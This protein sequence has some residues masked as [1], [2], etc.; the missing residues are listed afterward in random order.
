MKFAHGYGAK[1]KLLMRNMDNLGYIKSYGGVQNYPEKLHRLKNKLEFSQSLATISLL[2]HR[3]TNKAKE[4]IYTELRALAPSAKYKLVVKGDDIS[5]L[6]KKEI[7]ALLLAY[8]A[9]K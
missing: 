9:V 1:M 5:K 6:T 7:C 3:D 4:S 8:F 2:E